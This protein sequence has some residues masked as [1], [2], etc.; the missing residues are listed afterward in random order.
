MITTKKHGRIILYYWPD[1]NRGKTYLLNKRTVTQRAEFLFRH[2]KREAKI[3]RA[4]LHLRPFRDGYA[5][6]NREG[7]RLFYGRGPRKRGL[8]WN[9]TEPVIQIEVMH[10]MRDYDA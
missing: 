9:L 4:H 10:E 5:I 7:R 3:P 6:F 8:G 1:E 2:I